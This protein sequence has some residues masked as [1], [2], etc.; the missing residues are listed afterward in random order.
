MRISWSIGATTYSYLKCIVYDKLLKPRQS[1]WIT[2]YSWLICC[3]VNPREAIITTCVFHL[4]YS[5]RMRQLAMW[6]SSQRT[7]LIFP[8]HNRCHVVETLDRNILDTY[9][10][11]NVTEIFV[12]LHVCGT[13][14]DMFMATLLYKPR[15]FIYRSSLLGS[16]DMCLPLKVTPTWLEHSSK[17]WLNKA[18]PRLTFTIV[19][20][21]K[22]KFQ[23]KTCLLSDVHTCA[24]SCDI[25]RYFGTYFVEW[26]K[27]QSS[28][29]VSNYICVRKYLNI[30][31][32]FVNKS[33]Y[34]TKRG[35]AVG[36]LV[37]ALRSKPEGRGFDSR[38]CHW[39]F[40]FT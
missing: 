24:F 8:N 35:H 26:R 36:Q 9:K 6:F 2:L 11:L 29:A 33:V 21:N 4:C 18:V 38:W 28:V 40:S 31:K 12:E 25:P 7:R 39:N 37:E 19:F 5:R 1:F 32:L 13:W 15:H 14:L 23:N 30:L 3:F 27:T 20:I 22:D 16:S 34:F 17:P 10:F